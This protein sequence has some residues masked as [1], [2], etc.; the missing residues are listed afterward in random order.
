MSNL[1]K[2]KDKI[3]KNK[4]SKERIEALEEIVEELLIL[5]KTRNF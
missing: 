1:D 4:T 5:I 2:M 3:D